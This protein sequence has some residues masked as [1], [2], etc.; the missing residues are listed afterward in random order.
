M[1]SKLLTIRDVAGRLSLSTREVY[2]KIANEEVKALNI[3]KCSTFEIIK[4]IKKARV[5]A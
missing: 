4:L 3:Q 5:A 1:N 2:R